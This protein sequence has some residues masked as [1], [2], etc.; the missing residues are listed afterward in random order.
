MSTFETMKTAFGQKAKADG[1]FA[2]AYA[3]MNLAQEQAETAR[4]I[5]LLGN[6][7]SFSGP[8]GAEW[9]AIEALG[10]KLSEA[11]GTVAGALQEIAQARASA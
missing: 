2:I 4:A 3:I 10:N 7:F 6:G 9:G 1:S 5:K 8:E 11:A